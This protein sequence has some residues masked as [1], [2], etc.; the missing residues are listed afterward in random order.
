MKRIAIFKLLVSGVWLWLAFTAFFIVLRLSL[1]PI[2]GASL[3]SAY[4][5]YITN[6]L[7]LNPGTSEATG[8]SSAHVLLPALLYTIGLAGVQMG[9]WFG[10]HYLTTPHPDKLAA[11][12]SKVVMSLGYTLVLTPFVEV[13]LHV[14]GLGA[15]LVTSIRIRD[16]TT[17]QG[18]FLVLGSMLLLN[19]SV[20]IFT[21]YFVA[22]T[23]PD[24]APPGADSEA[25]TP[26]PR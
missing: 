13:L 6:L 11:V 10:V 22:H 23:A 9:M 1:S 16:F 24:N 4:L 18:C 20:S 12:I 15:L 17:A 21:H 5:R 7:S 8:L 3:M 25:E 19:N 26:P 14:P 2:Q